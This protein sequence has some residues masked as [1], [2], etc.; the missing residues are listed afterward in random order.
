M[1]TPLVVRSTL[2]KG[3]EGRVFHYLTNN[4]YRYKRRV[5]HPN[6]RAYFACSVRGCRAGMKAE[7]TSKEAANV[8]EPKAWL[9]SLPS[10]SCH[11]L[12]YGRRHPLQAGIIIIIAIIIGIVSII[13]MVIIVVSL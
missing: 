10:H 13:V 11:V 2:P 5:V 8:E 7:Y 12:E 6:G 4:C 1:Q 3:E 9:P